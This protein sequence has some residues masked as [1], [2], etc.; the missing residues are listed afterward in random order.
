MTDTAEL[1]DAHPL[2]AALRLDPVPPTQDAPQHAAARIWQGATHPGYLNMVGP[3]GGI[4][5]AQALSAVLAHPDRLGDP[6]SLTVNFVAALAPGAFRVVATPVRT[7]RTTQHWTVSMSQTDASGVEAVVLTATAVF[8]LRRQTW[9]AVDAVMPEVPRPESL[10]RN[11]G[12]GMVEWLN[13]YDMRL[14]AGQLPRHWD[15]TEADSVTQLWMRDDPPRPLDF[16]SLAA[17]A[18]VFFPRVWRR[19]A[20]MTPVGTVSMT[21]YFHATAQE[22][23]QTGS[24]Y[25]LGHARAQ[26]FF[27]GFFDQSAELWNAQGHLLATT[28]QIVYFKE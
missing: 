18:D 17:L 28:H 9:G 16:A 7:N 14:C 25:L 5:A 13:R 11:P 22:L 20:L 3:F 23:Q 4:T 2:D 12:T 10:P 24:D 1:V 15:G 21:V 19:R 27:H 6:L 26:S 8:A